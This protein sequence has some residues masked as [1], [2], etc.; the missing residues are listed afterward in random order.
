MMV[1]PEKLHIDDY[2]DWEARPFFFERN[3]GKK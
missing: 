3:N 1:F 2:L